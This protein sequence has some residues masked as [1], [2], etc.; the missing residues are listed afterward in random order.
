MYEEYFLSYQLNINNYKIFYEPS[1]QITH[2]M[3]ASTNVLPGKLKWIYSKES[4]IIHRKTNK[5][6]SI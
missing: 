6:F 2:L 5:I 4:H 3:H 1:I